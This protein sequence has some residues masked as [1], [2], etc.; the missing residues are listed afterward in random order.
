MFRAVPSSVNEGKLR[1]GDWVTPSR[2]YAKMHGEHRLGGDY[3]IIEDEVPVNELWWDGN[4]SREWGF[5]DG[6]GYKYKN[7][8]NSRKLNDLVTR[9]DNGEIIPPSKRFDENVEDVRYRTSEEFNQINQKFN[10]RLDELV[11]NPNQKDK[12]LHLGRSSEFL[13]DG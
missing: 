1:N 6:K 3:R 13:K 12:V 2:A 10:E 7:V 8:E 4:D 5:D 11:S 9:D